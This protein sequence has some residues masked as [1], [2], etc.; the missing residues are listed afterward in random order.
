MNETVKGL[1]KDIGVDFG[2]KDPKDNTEN[3]TLLK[4]ENKQQRLKQRER[5]K[6]LITEAEN[7]KSRQISDIKSSDCIIF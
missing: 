7:K 3:I 5:Q 1:L 6:K 2:A 4:E